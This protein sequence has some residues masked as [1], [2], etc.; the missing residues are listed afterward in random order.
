MC[1]LLLE[2]KDVANLAAVNEGQASMLEYSS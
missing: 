1:N 2:D